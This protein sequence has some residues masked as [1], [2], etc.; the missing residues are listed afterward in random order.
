MQTW[1][2]HAGWQWLIHNHP[3]AA[4][5]IYADWENDPQDQGWTNPWEAAGRRWSGLVS[6]IKDID[7]DSLDALPLAATDITRHDLF[8]FLPAATWLE[9]PQWV[10]AT[11]AASIQSHYVAL[12][13]A[14]TELPP[15]QR[16]AR[17]VQLQAAEKLWALAWLQ[18]SF[19]LADAMCVTGL[20]AAG[21]EDLLR[22]ACAVI[23]C[24]V[25]DGTKAYCFT[26]DLDEE[27]VQTRIWS[28]DS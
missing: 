15:H 8:A 2:Q 13:A 11:V 22:T 10:Y 28:V 23:E 6:G 9:L 21:V 20:D 18:P 27:W 5:A 17:T 1:C 25:A 3:A 16:R 24:I 14:G 26:P 12:Q 19:T 7:E 4:E